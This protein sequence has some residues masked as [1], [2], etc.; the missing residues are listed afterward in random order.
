MKALF[1]MSHSNTGRHTVQQLVSLI[2][3]L[4][5]IAVRLSKAQ[6]AVLNRLSAKLGMDKTNLIRMAIHRLGEVEGVLL[7]V[8]PER[9]ER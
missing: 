6:I 3:A 4:T 1:C 7:D 2:M 5:P 9:R 8:P